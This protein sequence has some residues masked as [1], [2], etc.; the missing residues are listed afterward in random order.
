M[1]QRVKGVAVIDLTNPGI[2]QYYSAVRYRRGEFFLVEKIEKIEQNR[3]KRKR[4][5]T[6]RGTW[7]TRQES[8]PM[9]RD[10]PADSR[11]KMD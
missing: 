5:K 9:K 4:R 3:E 2:G 8:Q 7:R 1:T 6:L 10:F 11:P